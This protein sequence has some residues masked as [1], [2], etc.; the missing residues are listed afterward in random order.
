MTDKGNSVRH[1]RRE[2]S[3]ETG[4]VRPD[5]ADR[6]ESRTEDAVGE[7]ELSAIN[8]RSWVVSSWTVGVGVSSPFESLGS[9]GVG[10]EGEGTGSECDGEHDRSTVD[11]L[12]L[13]HQLGE[14]YSIVGSERLG[15]LRL[16]LCERCNES[17]RR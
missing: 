3:A 16:S 4:A 15:L 12:M 17:Q 9:E 5:V 6:S 10:G 8:H 14:E 11:F 1:R 2:G 7:E 13:S